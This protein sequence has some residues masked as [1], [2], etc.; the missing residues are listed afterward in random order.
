MVVPQA[1]RQRSVADLVISIAT[2]VLTA[3]C[4]VAAGLMGFFLLAF[5]DHCPPPTCSVDGAVTAVGVALLAAVA[6]GVTGVFVTVVQLVRKAPAWPFA[7]G[8]FVLCGLA[9]V[10]G[11]VGYTAATGG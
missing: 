4:G 1:P 9:C 3:L 10:F 2:L 5:L 6:I 8:T 11:G 7:V